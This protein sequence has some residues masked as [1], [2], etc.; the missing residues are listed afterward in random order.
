LYKI[1]KYNEEIHRRL[2][3]FAFW[4][5]GFR[6]I[7]RQNDIDELTIR[8]DLL[9]FINN[10]LF[11]TKFIALKEKGDHND[12]LIKYQNQKYTKPIVVY[13]IKTFAKDKS[14][15]FN[16]YE[17]YKDIIKLANTKSQNK[18]TKT[19]LLL[20]GKY[21]PIQ[22]LFKGKNKLILPTKFSKKEK[23]IRKP[24]IFKTEA[25]LSKTN[26]DELQADFNNIHIRTSRWK[27]AYGI[28]ALSWEVTK[29]T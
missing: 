26:D 2:V 14:K 29:T 5:L 16:K 8:H 21:N 9:C 25:I 7:Q 19:Y 22:K 11:K 10:D 23:Y 17:F 24:K 13:E 4:S 3:E 12:I 18:N 1:N 20:L 28:A 15:V 27:I 6:I